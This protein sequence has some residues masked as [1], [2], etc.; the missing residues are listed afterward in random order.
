MLFS[1]RA[2]APANVVRAHRSPLALMAL[3]ANGGLLA[4]ASVKGTVIRVFATPSLD[5]LYQFRRGTRETRIYSLAFN[6]A[7][8]LLAAGSERGT[9]HLW[10]VGRAAGDKEKDKAGSSSSAPPSSFNGSGNGAHSPAEST[11][12]HSTTDAGYEAFV[13]DR[14]NGGGSGTVGTALRRRSLHLTASLT[15]AAASYLPSGL[16]EMWEPTRDFAW[17]RLPPTGN[18]ANTLNGAGAGERRWVFL[19]LP[20]MKNPL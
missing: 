8:T 19:F 6:G 10:R 2:L 5:K 1:T 9:V 7:G 13:A 14:A 18:T 4:T 3:S 17:L 11:D 20:I 15:R 12:G 16:A